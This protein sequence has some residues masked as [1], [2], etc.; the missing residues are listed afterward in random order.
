MRCYFMRG[1]RI[2]GVTFLKDAPDHELIRQARTLFVTGAKTEH[3][4][5]F[6]VWGETD[7]FI[8][9]LRT[10]MSCTFKIEHCP[11]RTAEDFSDRGLNRKR[12]YPACRDSA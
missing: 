8:E 9:S 12:E 4:D 6:E 3:F 2:E 5:G 10:T 1:G 11:V 7:L